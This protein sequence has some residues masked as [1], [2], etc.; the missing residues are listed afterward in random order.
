[1]KSQNISLE[2]KPKTLG[3]LFLP[4]P[5]RQADVNSKT[6]SANLMHNLWQKNNCLKKRSNCPVLR[7]RIKSVHDFKC[8]DW[9][10]MEYLPWREKKRN[11]F[12]LLLYIYIYTYLKFIYM[13][14]HKQPFPSNM[15]V[16][17]TEK[18]KRRDLVLIR[19]K[20]AL[21]LTDFSM[22]H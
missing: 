11:K 10:M 13:H 17:N 3:F 16:F 7:I 4:L 5:V 22:S 18:V 14:I 9:T 2:N 20:V 6:F 15:N 12:C 19:T 21:Y 8:S 1:M